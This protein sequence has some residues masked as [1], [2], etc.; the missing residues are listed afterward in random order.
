MWW[1]V[2]I[3]IVIFF[4]LSLIVVGQNEVVVVERLG[5]FHGIFKAGLQMVYVPIFSIRG[6]DWRFKNAE[7][8]SFESLKAW[9]IPLSTLR[10]DPKPHDCQTSDNFSVSLDVV[11]NFKIADVKKAVYMNYNVFGDLEDKFETRLYEVMRSFKFDELDIGKIKERFNV[12]EFNEQLVSG[13]AIEDFR[14]QKIIYPRGIVD[15]TVAT[16]TLQIQHH[17][18]I[19]RLKSEREHEL[20]MLTGK[21]EELMAKQELERLN[22]EHEWAMHLKEAESKQTIAKLAMSANYELW[23]RLKD[24]PGL[25]SLLV[26]QEQSKAAIALGKGGKGNKLI[27]L[28]DGKSSLGGLP[29][30]KELLSQ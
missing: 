6:V 28:S 16:Q 29:V 18:E 25:V 15:A 4:G 11:M 2:L 13:I 7:A 10:Y 30:I 1:I 17:A 20:A 8:N 12:V 5:K 21:R 14:V 22:A 3:G 23:D 19:E 9:R 26:A 27:I 24:N